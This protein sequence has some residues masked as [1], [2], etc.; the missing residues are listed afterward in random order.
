MNE[1]EKKCYERDGFVIIKNILPKQE[2]KELV[3][4]IDPIIRKNRNKIGNSN[5][6]R[7]IQGMCITGTNNIQQPIKGKYR[8]WSAIY[9]NPRLQKIIDEI[10]PRKRWRWNYGAINGLG[11]IHLRFPIGKTWRPPKHGWHIDDSTDKINPYKSIT[12]L[13]IIHDIKKGGGGT[14]LYRGSHHKI[15]YWIHNLQNKI[16]LDDYI[17]KTVNDAKNN[18]ME[19]E[20]IEATGEEGDLLL[21]H[22]NLVHSASICGKHHKTRITFNLSIYNE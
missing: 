16:S 21:M 2:C 3:K 19:N 18:D 10:H 4:Q 14:A 6:N 12:L 7:K 15:S 22:P 5:R 9:E 11:W 17:T 20:I 1:Y 13:P 8:K